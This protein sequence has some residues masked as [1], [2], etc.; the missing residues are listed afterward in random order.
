MLPLELIIRA[1]SIVFGLV[2]FVFAIMVGGFVFVVIG[3]FLFLVA[4]I[5]YIRVLWNQRKN[6]IG[7]N[8]SIIDA[9]YTVI[10]TKDSDD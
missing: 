10:E 3:T 1:L 8:D 9:E 5:F 6:K 2:A 7:A 4:I